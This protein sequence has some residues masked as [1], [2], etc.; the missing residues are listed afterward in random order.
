MYSSCLP[1]TRTGSC[2]NPSTE[3]AGCGGAA[4]GPQDFPGEKRAPSKARGLGKQ[5]ET[6]PPRER[7][8]GGAQSR[9]NPQGLGTPKQTLPK[10]F[11]VNL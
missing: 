6:P 3:R 4:E 1:K 5:G 10:A 8:R 2:R 9:E 11:H 7:I